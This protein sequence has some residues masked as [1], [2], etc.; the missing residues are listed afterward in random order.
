MERKSKL[1]ET[2]E[3]I[4]LLRRAEVARPRSGE[5]RCPEQPQFP[6]HASVHIRERTGPQ[7]IAVAKSPSQRIITAATD[8]SVS[9]RNSEVGLAEGD[10]PVPD[11]VTESR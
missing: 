5:I 11:A 6:R 10:F 7:R 2:E 8:C 9:T 3:Q 1:R 4:P